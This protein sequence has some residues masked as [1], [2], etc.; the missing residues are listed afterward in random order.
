MI[1]LPGIKKEDIDIAVE[2]DFLTVRAERRREFED[3]T[4]QLHRTELEFGRVERS[5]R[6][7]TAVD[8][9]KLRASFDCGVLKLEMPKMATSKTASVKVPISDENKMYNTA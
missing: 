9:T 2:G 3:K 7:P 5:F 8:R 4:F 6:I 1:D